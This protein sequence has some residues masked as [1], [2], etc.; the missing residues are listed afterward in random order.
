MAAQ[1]LLGKPVATEIRER[2]KTYV[3][4]ERRQRGTV[5]GLAVVLVGEDAPSQIYVGLKHQAAVAAGMRS[6][7]RRLPEQSRT[8]DVRAVVEALNQDPGVNGILVQFPLPPHIDRQQVLDHIDANK[9]VDGLTRL[10]QGSLAQNIPGLRPC[11]AVGI[12]DI[13]AHYHIPLAGRRAVVI[14]RSALVGLPAALMLMQEQATVT[15]VHS[16]TWGSADI[17]RQAD[18]L[19]AAAGRPGLVDGT[20]IKPGA[21]VVDVGIH[22][23][24]H[25][26]VGDVVSQHAEE[27]ASAVTPVP[28]G[29]GPMTIAELMQN[30]WLAYCDQV[31]R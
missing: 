24:D 17:A 19:V 11:T 30:T 7:E 5:P 8:E 12:M 6:I 28:G 16:R 18:I 26:I 10:S 3:A 14:G 13:L 15:I 1:K 22:R 2:V 29:I 21:V 31:G 23:T 4:E 20:W 9:D 27:L 25:G